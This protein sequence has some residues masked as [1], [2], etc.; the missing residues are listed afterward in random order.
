MGGYLEKSANMFL[1]M[2][3]QLQK[4]TRTMFN[5]GFPNYGTE[6]KQETKPQD[7]KP[8]NNKDKK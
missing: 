5:F 2:Q 3:Q 6:T 7:P 8:E 4:Q 1:E